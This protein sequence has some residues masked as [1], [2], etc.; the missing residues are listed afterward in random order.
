MGSFEAPGSRHPD[1][2]NR[3]ISHPTDH[4]DERRDI[5]T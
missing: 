2:Q 3:I 1:A 4:V 5:R